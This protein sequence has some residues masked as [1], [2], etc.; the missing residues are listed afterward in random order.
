MDYTKYV[1]Y[2]KNKNIILFDHQYR[3][4]YYKLNRLRNLNNQTGGGNY[5]NNYYLFKN[6]SNNDI[7]NIINSS[8]S[9]NVKLGYLYHLIYN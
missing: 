5:N 2:L 8:L 4:S 1:Q 7:I 3:L 6:K 9:H